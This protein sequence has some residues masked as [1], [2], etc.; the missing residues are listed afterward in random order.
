[1][2]KHYGQIVEYTLRKK[3]FNISTLAK[4]VNVNR[5]TIYNWFDQ[6]RLKT[7]IILQIGLATELDF[8]VQFPELFTPNQFELNHISSTEDETLSESIYKN[9]YLVLLEKYNEILSNALEIGKEGQLLVL[10]TVAYQLA[11]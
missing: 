11:A 4:L 9:K 3:G 6:R 10:L 8:S 7:N 5:R 2:D 1:M